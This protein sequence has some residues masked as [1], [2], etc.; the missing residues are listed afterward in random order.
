MRENPFKPAYTLA[1]RHLQ[2][3]YPAFFSKTKYFEVE[4]EIFELPDG[5]FVECIW[6]NKPRKDSH[7]PI[8]TLFHGLAGGFNSPY[9]QRVMLALEKENLSVVL[10]HFRGCGK[11][12]NTLPRSYHSGETED[13][14]AWF[15]ELKTRHP[16]NPLF[17]IGYSLGGNMLLKLLGEVGNDSLLEACI[18]VSAPMQ[19]EISADKMD[20]GFSKLY[21]H[22]L[23]KNLKR[24]L[25]KKYKMHD[26]QS[27]IGLSE[28]DVQKL[29]SFWE[30]DDAYTAPIHGFNSAK[31]Y[32]EKSSSKQFLKDIK[33]NTLI[34]HAH[35]DPFM[36]PE[37]LPNENELSTS[38]KL[39][40]YPNG[41][42]VGFVGG[43]LF[44]PHYWLE[45]R[46]VNYF[47]Y[48]ATN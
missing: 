18:S 48:N 14:K 3:L 9:I 7:K 11:E 29:N 36:T 40:V 19:L 20:T 43:T 41:G 34:I 16:S 8:V 27:I 23:M 31:D 30:F 28:N 24:D 32:Y 6:H 4:L 12:M 15:R 33:T 44:K 46:I 39:E 25:L 42:H 35:D 1:N 37:I 13:A 45:E 38:V 21:Q 5:D 10:M 17:A 47:C 2:T 22:H 26:M